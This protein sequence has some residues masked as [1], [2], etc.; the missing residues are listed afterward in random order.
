MSSSV[1]NNLNAY[2]YIILKLSE[3][4]TACKGS[5][6]INTNELLDLCG[7][8]GATKQTREKFI[9][10]NVYTLTDLLRI[11]RDPMKDDIIKLYL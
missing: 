3:A 5:I 4:R 11:E 2:Y 1:L 8:A 9:Y 10:D 6:S 7:Y